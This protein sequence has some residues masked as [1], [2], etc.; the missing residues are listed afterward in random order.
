MPHRALELWSGTAAALLALA[1]PAIV[2]AAFAHEPVDVLLP[3]L[4]PLLLLLTLPGLL[5]GGGAHAH[6]VRREPLGRGAVAVGASALGI[7]LACAT[8]FFLAAYGTG[9]LQA[10]AVVRAY[11]DRASFLRNT[12]YLWLWLAQGL[13]CALGVCAAVAGRTP[14]R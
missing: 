9:F 8:A 13:A 7:G 11:P 6:A 5:V 10:E 1:A 4:V 3:P 2:V 14:S 12:W